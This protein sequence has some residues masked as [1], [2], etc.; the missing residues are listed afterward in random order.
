MRRKT[1]LL[2]VIL[3]I[4]WQIG[5]GQDSKQDMDSIR[6]QTL[7]DFIPTQDS[8]IFDQNPTLFARRL[9]SLVVLKDSILLFLSSIESQIDSLEQIIGR[10]SG[11]NIPD[12]TKSNVINDWSF[13]VKEV[14]TYMNTIT[15]KVVL[16]GLKN[17]DVFVSAGVDVYEQEIT[18][19]NHKGTTPIFFRGSIEEDEQV[20]TLKTSIEKNRWKIKNVAL[21]VNVHL[22][23]DGK[24]YEPLNKFELEDMGKK[25]IYL[26]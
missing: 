23:M 3:G 5:F 10:S 2:L 18:N 15:I 8:T 12:K 25:Y 6:L 16:S 20:I 17:K 13:I 4:I 26:L 14:T 9:D 19:K 22:R 24:I 7:Q 11:I 21:R 1:L